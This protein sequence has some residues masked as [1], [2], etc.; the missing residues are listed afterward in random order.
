MVPAME[1]LEICQVVEYRVDSVIQVAIEET[2]IEKR[3]TD[4]IC[5]LTHHMT[6]PFIL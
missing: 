4:L 1:F 6:T 5:L 3:F 2:V